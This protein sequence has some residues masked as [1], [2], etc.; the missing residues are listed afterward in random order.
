MFGWIGNFAAD[1]SG[2]TAIEYAAAAGIVGIALVVGLE[3]AGGW[4][5][6]MVGL[7]QER[8]DQAVTKSGLGALAPSAG[9]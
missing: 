3:W 9:N 5:G 6:D 2:T 7:S 8:I 1:E 4:I